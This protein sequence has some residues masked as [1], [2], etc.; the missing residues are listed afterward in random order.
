L[1]KLALVLTVAFILY[2]LRL[3]LRQGQRFSV[4]LWIS[5]VWF[6]L[7]ASRPL[8]YFIH[9]SLFVA[10]NQTIAWQQGSVETIQSNPL[11]RNV[12]IVLMI[13][14]LITLIRHRQFQ[15]K[16]SDNRWL[17]AFLSV[18]LISL[19]WSEYP[20]II[21]KRWIRLAGDII[22]ILIIITEKDTEERIY[23]IIRRM[24]IL[25]LPLSLLFVKFY[26]PLGRIY[27]LFG[28]QMWVGV[29][30][31]K[32]SLGMLC[33]FTGIVLVW[34][35][36]SKWPHID[37]LD[38]GLLAMG[39]YLLVGSKS[40]TS[41]VVFFLGISLLVAQAR[42][43]GDVRKLNRVIIIGLVSLLIIQV[44]AVFFLNQS[45]SPIFFSA[46]GRDSSFT[47][48]VP[49]WAELIKM[50][51]QAPFLGYGFSSFWLDS[52]RVAEVW[53]R[54]G[55]TPTTAHNGYIE[56]FVDMGIIGLL[57]LFLLL[58]QTYK[59]IVL[60]FENNP[61]LGE[62]K[63][64][65]FAMVFFHNFTESTFGKPFTLLW[66]LFLLSSIVIKTK[67]GKETDLAS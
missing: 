47:G 57:V 26:P 56:I 4:G 3:D 43:K 46:V 8:V 34:R 7:S 12:L 59:N 38:A 2:A 33:A 63:I 23:R 30:D 52:E 6:A 22:A 16:L 1:A 42:M 13:L 18:C 67:P 9:P 66:L 32:N 65:L 60:S 41:A 55:W 54:V 61:R 31:H 24:T 62:L 44:V 15:L 17:I 29:T 58:A 36:L 27:T 53:R 39:G 35:N 10:F 49:L 48:R 28:A 19:F 40:S 5:F 45:L 20:A 11:D 14:G 25:L 50:G 21:L 51:S 64:V 37:W